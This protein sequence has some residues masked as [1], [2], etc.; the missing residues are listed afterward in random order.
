M[1]RI[2]FCIDALDYLLFRPI[3]IIASNGDDMFVS[4]I[5]IGFCNA[6][7]LSVSHIWSFRKNI[8]ELFRAISS[9]V[10]WNIGREAQPLSRPGNR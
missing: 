1:K 3:P 9:C 7:D 8:A 10:F 4:T 2:R 6:L 5:R